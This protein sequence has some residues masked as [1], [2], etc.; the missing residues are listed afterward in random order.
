[1][2]PSRIAPSSKHM[3]GGDHNQV[4]EWCKDL[5]A[6]SERSYNERTPVKKVSGG[7]GKSVDGGSCGADKER[8]KD[9]DNKS[10]ADKRHIQ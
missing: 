7:G 6:T 9:R 4:V 2:W 8:G 5:T 1:M 3:S 10:G